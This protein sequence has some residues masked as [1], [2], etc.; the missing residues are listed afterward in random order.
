MNT[1]ATAKAA[2]AGQ[3][4][5]ATATST[6]QNNESSSQAPA[7]NPMLTALALGTGVLFANKDS[8]F[9]LG[10]KTTGT[11]D[12]ALGANIGDTTVQMP[13]LST[14]TTTATG[15]LMDS[16]GGFFDN[17]AGGLK[18][19]TTDPTTG[20]ATTGGINDLT[21]VVGNVVASS[22]INALFS[23]ISGL[24]GGGGGGGGSSSDGGGT[25]ICTRMHA[26]GYLGGDL[27]YADEV[28]GRHLAAV[29]PKLI[30]WYHSWA[31]PFVANWMHG[32][33]LASKAVIQLLRI[34]VFIWSLW[35]LY[36]VFALDL[37]DEGGE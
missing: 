21:N 19:A 6:V 16:I 30:E 18:S 12:S 2:T 3:L 33:T 13:T 15:S 9:G 14:P 24:F 8:I 1:A 31:K 29:N 28:Y 22:G 4:N 23:G 20:Q 35:M 7:V 25:V 17:V 36:D 37:L 26:L 32:T 10:K 27:Y 34:P 5:T 11:S